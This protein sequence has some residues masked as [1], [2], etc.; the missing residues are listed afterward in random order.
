[1]IDT[2]I[3]LITGGS[4]SGKTA[5]SNYLASNLPKESVIL[6]QDNYFI[7]YSKYTNEELDDINFDIPEAF[8]TDVLIDNVKDLCNHRPVQLPIYDFRL[9]KIGHWETYN[10]EPSYIIIEGIMTFESKAL[11]DMASVKIFVNTPLDIMLWRRLNRDRN[12]RFFDIRSSLSR[13]IKFI[14]HSYT[15]II[16]PNINRSDLIINGTAPYERSIVKEI[17]SFISVH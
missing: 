1:M 9:H 16:Y 10:K 3:I 8:L 7:D 4:C 12:D 6:S 14:R 17:L 11:Y 5:L 15:N 13:Y 2:K